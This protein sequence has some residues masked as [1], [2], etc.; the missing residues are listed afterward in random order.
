MFKINHNQTKKDKKLK[1]NIKNLKINNLK[2][3]I[4][5]KQKEIFKRI[6]KKKLII[7]KYKLRKKETIILLKNKKVKIKTQISKNFK[8]N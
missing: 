6:N 5:I 8:I 1:V 2:L 3:I 7:K 4:L